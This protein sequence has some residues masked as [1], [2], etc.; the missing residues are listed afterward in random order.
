MPPRL[1]RVVVSVTALVMLVVLIGA[2][3]QGVETSFER[4]EFQRQ[5]GLVDVG[6]FQLHFYCLGKGSPPVI[7]EAAA[8]SLSAAWGWVQ[9]EVANVTRVC[10]YDRAGL[11]WSES[12]DGRY[13]PSQVPND[14]HALL[15][16]SREE[17]PFVIVGQEL[18]A[19]FARIFAARY[20]AQTLALVLVDD[21]TSNDRSDVTTPFVESWPWLARAGIFRVND[22]LSAL[23][24]PLPGK[25]GGAMRAFL[26]RP[27]HLTR[28]AAEISRMN[29]VE[30]AARQAQP[31]PS[32]AIT[33]V[34]IGYSARPVMLA[35]HNDAAKVT[36]AIEQALS[37][38]RE[39][40]PKSSH[41]R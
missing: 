38:A 2:T 8:G 9:P 19:A 4:R 27:D 34:T 10:S 30:G 25:S 26:N 41:A 31:D 12:R 33:S 5:G 21:P 39:A 23:A 22:R 11:G 14:L 36:K 37:A 24:L 40:H 20:P 18:G 6:G 35:D 3:Y 28:A 7:L 29:E 1:R 17:G 32:I 13:D 16:E 15:N